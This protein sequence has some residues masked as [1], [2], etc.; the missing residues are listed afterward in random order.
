[1]KHDEYFPDTLY[2][3]ELYAVIVID[4]Q[5]LYR[6]RVVSKRQR[7]R[8]EICCR[9]SVDSVQYVL[10]KIK[11]AHAQTD[12]HRCTHHILPSPNHGEGRLS[13]FMFLV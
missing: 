2:N 5:Y 4:T 7:R 1:M 13:W 10:I 9:G 8:N 12:L 6:C 3:F 11:S